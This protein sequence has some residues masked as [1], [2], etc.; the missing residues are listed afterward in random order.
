MKQVRG[1]RLPVA[2]S[3]APRAG[4]WIETVEAA[5]NQADAAGRTPRGVVYTADKKA[6]KELQAVVGKLMP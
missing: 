2:L 1:G 5:M 4:A 6:L 3:V